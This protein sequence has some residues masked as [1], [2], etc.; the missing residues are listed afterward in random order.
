MGA[1]PWAAQARSLCVVGDADPLAVQVEDPL[2]QLSGRERTVA[3]AVARGLSNKEV[4]GE[5]YISLK[6]VD[7]HLQ[8]IYRKLDIRSRTRLAVL[9]HA[10]VPS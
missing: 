5:L 1:R 7:A 8:Q 10:P 9:C 3:F 2:A 4:A 6:T